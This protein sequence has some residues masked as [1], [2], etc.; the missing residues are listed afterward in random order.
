V[1][2]N[3]TGVDIVKIRSKLADVDFEFG[4]FEYKQDHLIIHSASHQPMQTKVYVSPDDILSGL[5]KAL[6]NPMVWVYIIGFPF[7]LIRY[8]RRK[9]AKSDRKE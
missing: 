4:S 5:G 1:V 2:N 9:R 7:F 3:L 8:R 6:A